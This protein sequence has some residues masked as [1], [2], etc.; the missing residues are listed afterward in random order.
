MKVEYDNHEGDGVK[1]MKTEHWEPPD[2]KKQ[3]GYI[4]DMRSSRD[5]PVDKMGAEKCYDTEAPDH[6]GVFRV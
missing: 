6:V 2:W 1:P 5:A 3:L 4:R